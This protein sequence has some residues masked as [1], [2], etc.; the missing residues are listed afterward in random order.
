MDFHIYG[1]GEA[2]GALTKLVNDL[3][4]A[5]CVLFHPFMPIW[6]SRR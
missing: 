5:D 6:R 4:V 1:N 2:M 3:G